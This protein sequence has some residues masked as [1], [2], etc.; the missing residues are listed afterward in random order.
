MLDFRNMLRDYYRLRDGAALPKI[1]F[2]DL[3]HSAA[4]L[5]HAA[6]VPTQAIKS[7]LGHRSTRTTEEIYM[8]T[9]GEMEAEA[10][11]TMNGILTA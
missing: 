11:D 2:H 10:A 4:T 3:R 7:L 1:R 8:H 9:T 6:G 5:L